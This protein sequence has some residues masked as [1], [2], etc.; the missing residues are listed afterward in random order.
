MRYI[1]QGIDGLDGASQTFGTVLTIGER[2]NRGIPT[3]TDKFFI[4]K[5]IA[6]SKQLGSR[7]G[8]VRENDPEFARFNGSDKAELRSVIRFDI[9]HPVHLRD[10]WESMV[11]C[12]QFQLLAQQIPK[13]PTHPN[14][15]C[16]FQKGK[17][18]PCK[19]RARLAFQLRWP[20]HEAWSVLPTPTCLFSTRSWYNINRVLLPFFKDLHKQAMNLGYHKYTFYGL[21][22]RMTL[23]KRMTG[24]G[25]LVPA[26]SLSA[27]FER[28]TNFRDFLAHNQQ[29]RGNFSSLLETNLDDGEL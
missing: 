5:P 18:A 8:L 11:D 19:P 26:I 29:M 6:V 25:G 21:P 9:V 22:C 1:Y 7:K 10:G 4:K 28:G 12:F 14:N 23:S 3:N 15:L 27:E 16:E 17:P 24:K 20:E 13:N 2:S